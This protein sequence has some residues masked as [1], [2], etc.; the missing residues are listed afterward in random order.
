[1]SSRVL[2]LFNEITRE[3]TGFITQRESPL[4]PGVFFEVNNSTEIEPPLFDRDSIPIFNEGTWVLEK[5]YR[6]QI[7]YDEFGT[8]IIIKKLGLPEG[9][10]CATPPLSIMKLS[11]KAEA[12][13]Q[14]SDDIQKGFNS[15]D[16]FYPSSIPDQNNILMVSI[17]GGNLWCSSKPDKWDFTYHTVRQAQKVLSSMTLHIQSIQ[18]RYAA[19][20]V[21]IEEATSFAEL[22]KI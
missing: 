5:D 6:D 16:L 14:C 1:M 4:E 11:K 10:L 19:L 22:D 13:K 7:W 2:Y 21:K 3:Y 9:N 17:F 8:E 20:L 18:L 15:G 12:S